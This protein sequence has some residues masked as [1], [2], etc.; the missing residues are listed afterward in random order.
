MD[1]LNLA[2]KPILAS[3]TMMVSEAVARMV[4]NNVGAVVVTD[5]S[6]H[7]VGMF[8]ERDVMCRVTFK[9]IAAD[10][11][12][13]SSVMTRPVQTVP[14]ETG[15]EEALDLMIRGRFHHLPIVDTLDRAI[16]IVSLRYLLMRRLGENRLLRKLAEP[17]FA[18]IA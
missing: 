3:P 15:I 14:P 12:P 16:A 17:E 6:R 4:A 7:I 10:E 5:R 13:L 9:R 18:G 8:T 1:L 11:M 2:R